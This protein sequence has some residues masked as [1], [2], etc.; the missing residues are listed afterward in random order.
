MVFIGKHLHA[1]A[2][3]AA[4]TDCL[5]ADQEGLPSAD[6]FPAWD[7]HGTGETCQHEHPEL[8]AG[9]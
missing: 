2:L 8:L 5:M 3:R 1:G 6:P 9:A 4:L 7:T